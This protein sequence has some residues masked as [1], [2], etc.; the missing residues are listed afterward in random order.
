MAYQ[1]EYSNFV[2]TELEKLRRGNTVEKQRYRNAMTTI[3]RVMSN[4]LNRDFSKVL[5]DNFKA[6]DVLQQYRIFFKIINNPMSNGIDVVY[7][8]WMNDEESIHQQGSSTDA[9]AVFRDNLA[10]GLIQ[11]Y[12][13][14]L[15]QLAPSYKRF[16]PWTEPT[17][18]VALQRQTVPPAPQLG[19]YSTLFLSQVMANDFRI[20]SITVTV[21]DQGLATELLREL[22]I[23]ADRDG[24]S[25]NYEL[26]QTSEN[27]RK[28]RHLLEKHSFEWHSDVDGMELWERKPRR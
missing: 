5:P 3:E 20:D 13:P 12:Q 26:Q 10:N 14:P 27:Y 19:S 6:A 2:E 8:A 11:I 24:I 16:D 18:Y 4:P 15:P 28:S 17:V 23:E 1:R 25:L 21:E 22:C 9:Y 7:F